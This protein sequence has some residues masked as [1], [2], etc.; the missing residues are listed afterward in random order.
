MKHIFFI[1]RVNKTTYLLRSAPMFDNW[2]CC[3]ERVLFD[4]DG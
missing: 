3:G 1:F 2:E 4:E